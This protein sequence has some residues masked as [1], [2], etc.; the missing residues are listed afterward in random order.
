MC[1]LL[2]CQRSTARCYVRPG[3]LLL[4]QIH[5]GHH[6]RTGQSV[7]QTTALVPV[8]LHNVLNLD[9]TAACVCVCDIFVQQSLREEPQFRECRMYVN[10]RSSSYTNDSS[11]W[12]LP[13]V[14]CPLHC[15]GQNIKSLACPVSNIRCPFSG[16]SVNNFK[17]P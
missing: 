1:S 9:L 11:R 6:D 10:V 17:W 5:A 2:S 16:Q 13:I 15:I 12:L 8:K 14:G 3:E 7:P 4:V